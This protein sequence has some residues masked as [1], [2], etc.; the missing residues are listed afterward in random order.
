MR[1]VNAF[2]RAPNTYS[3]YVSWAYVCP[4]RWRE[5]G[6]GPEIR[7]SRVICGSDVPWF[8][9]SSCSVVDGVDAPG[10]FF[11]DTTK[12]EPKE[13]PDGRRFWYFV[14]W[15]TWMAIGFGSRKV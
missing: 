2:F 13:N 6:G 15:E 3:S 14:F 5:S 12:C 4:D 11:M 7:F 9:W 10:C 1:N 8:G